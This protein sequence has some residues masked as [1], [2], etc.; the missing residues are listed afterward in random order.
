VSPGGPAG[1][2]DA[3]TAGDHSGDSSSMFEL[4]R[5][6]ESDGYTADMI[7]DDGR[8]RCRECDEASPPGEFEATGLRRSEGASDPDDMVAV[9][10]L[11]CPRCGAKGVF[12]G[13]YGAEAAPEDADVLRQLDTRGESGRYG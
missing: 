11:T 1:T 4:I 9:V 12:V 7:P 10:G 3:M 6:L 13:H 5:D 2:A 8:V